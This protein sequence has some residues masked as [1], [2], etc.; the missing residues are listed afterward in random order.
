MQLHHQK[1]HFLMRSLLLTV[2]FV[3]L[4][5]MGC[6]E[7]TRTDHK[8]QEQTAKALP[9]DTSTPPLWETWCFAEKT[10]SPITDGAYNYH[11]VKLQQQPANAIAGVVYNFP[12]GTDSFRASI[13]GVMLPEDQTINA[14]LQGYAEGEHYTQQAKYRLLSNALEL[15]YKTPQGEMAT[16]PRVSCVVFDSLLKEYRQSIFK[17]LINTSDRSRLRQLDSLKAYGFTEADLENIRFMERTV[18]LDRDPSTMEYLIYLMDPTLCGS[19]GCNLLVVD[20]K[21]TIVADITVTKLPIYTV[22]EDI[23]TTMTRKG[24]WKDLFVYSKGMRRLAPRNGIYP[25]NPSGEEEVLLEQLTG[26]PESYSLLMDYLE[27]E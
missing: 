25:T 19:G 20:S 4:T 8:E 16:L 21:N 15:N 24:Q 14:T 27:Q 6:K 23:E 18:D 9:S 3:F 12:Y 13:K 17:N 22:I 5:I 11:L 2:S 10:S 1:N 26:F 7:Q